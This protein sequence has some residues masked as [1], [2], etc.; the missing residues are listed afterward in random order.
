LERIELLQQNLAIEPDLRSFTGFVLESVNRLGGSGFA[1]VVAL[2][3]LIERLRGAGATTGHLMP[4]S[5]MLEGRDMFVQWGIQERVKIST[6]RGMPNSADINQLRAYLLNSTAS[7]DP[8]VLLQRN[9]EMLRHF[10]ETRAR[11]EKELD[12][13]Q[14]TLR[15]RQQELMEFSHQV[16]TDALTGIFNRRAFDAKVRQAFL[17][18]M[19][20]KSA[21]LSLMFFDLD[22]FKQINDEFGHQFGDAYLNKM[23]CTLREVIREDVDFAFR[24][25]GDEFAV[26]LYADYPL[27]C[28]KAK[29]VLGLMENKVSIGI[30]AINKGT[31]D[32]LTLEE[33]IGRADRALYEAKHRGRGQA[34]VDLCPVQL[35]GKCQ[36][37]CP[38]MA[39]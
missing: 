21:P 31:P 36:L 22:Y 11:A 4:V 25:G 16:E 33:F 37:P 28:E 2:L 9:A 5:L 17:H 13:L 35:Q 34:V 29:Q 26:V 30:T 8:D 24:F 38:E 6:L 18:T 20:Q 39:I 32:D 15:E 19:R 7:A 1:A 12:V 14:R 3:N 10:N 27:A 23:A